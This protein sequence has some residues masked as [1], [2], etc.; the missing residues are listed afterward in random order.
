MKNTARNKRCY[1]WAGVFVLLAAGASAFFPVLRNG[2][3]NW[4]D[5]AQLLANPLV[6]EV[7]FRNTVEIFRSR[8]VSEY[9]PL[10]TALFSVEYGLFGLQPAVY[11]LHSLFLH[12]ANTLLVFFLL[13]LLGRNLPAALAGA[14][15]FEINPLQVQAVAWISARKDLLFAFF[16]LLAL[17]TFIFYHN[18]QSARFYLISIIFFILSLFCKTTA[19]TLPP[20]ILLWLSCFRR[21]LL[22]KDW[23]V[24]LPF[25][26][27]AL[28]VGVPALMMQTARYPGSA[29]HLG[30]SGE[31]VLLFFRNLG[32]Y[33]IRVLL[34][35]Q[36]SPVYLFPARVAFFDV[37]V[38]GSVLLVCLLAV[39]LSANRGKNR[40]ILF[41]TGFFI[42]TLLPVLRLIPFAGIEV[43]ANRFMYLPLAAAGYLIS[44]GFSGLLS[45]AGEVKRLKAVIILSGFMIAVFLAVGTGYRCRFWRDGGTLWNE[46]LRQQGGSDLIYHM[47]AD[48]AFRSGRYPE[49]VSLC[50][51][52]IALNPAMAYSY[53]L[54]ARA[55]R[56]LGEEKA[57]AETGALYFEVLKKLGMGK[58]YNTT[59]P[60]DPTDRSD[61]EEAASCRK[62][63]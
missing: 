42:V 31:N 60:T 3:T 63:K 26:I 59:D 20:V 22:K 39:W 46:A 29:A 36:L 2:F 14:L 49:T 21:R 5:P 53:L 47:L 12:L 62:K 44:G 24:L 56:A 11:H 33:V 15:F 32:F 45:R 43:A 40:D 55:Q 23:I 28:A 38:A 41:G 18:R 54:K 4:D 51:R 7:S 9:H 58:N 37:S 10:V 50:D 1:I 8:V 48:H 25:F 52:A 30:L 35:V 17:I 16:Y 34:P 61:S 13:F 57:A 19:V 6:R 27:L